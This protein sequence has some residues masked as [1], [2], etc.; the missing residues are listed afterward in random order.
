MAL[1]K[2]ILKKKS[3]VIGASYYETSY[4]HSEMENV[5]LVK[6]TSCTCYGGKSTDKFSVEK[7]FYKNY[8]CK[9]TPEGMVER[10]WYYRGRV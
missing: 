5:E 7:R 3:P 6:V 4:N 10:K 9:R 8:E 2:P 1:I